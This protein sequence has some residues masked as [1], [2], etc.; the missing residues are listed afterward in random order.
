MSQ[1]VAS[2][3]PLARSESSS[4]RVWLWL[5]I[6]ILILM[7]LASGMG[8]FVNETYARLT[9][10]WAVQGRA[11]DFANLVLVVPTLAISG[12]LAARGSKRAALVWLGAIL[13]TIYNF[14]LYS[15]DVIFNSMF[16]AYIW[17]L[18]CS[19]YSLIFA[20][21]LWNQGDALQKQM[22]G[23]AS[24]KAAGIA[25]GIGA[26]LFAF[27]WLSVIVPAM[28]AG[29]IPAEIVEA[30]IPTNPVH[31]LDL[32]LA[33]PAM[34]LTAL[35]LRNG[36]RLSY[37]FAPGLLGFGIFIGLGVLAI[38]AFSALA[39]M[40]W[41]LPGAIMMG[42]ISAAYTIILVWYLRDVTE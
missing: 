41:S 9:E 5:T 34:A 10:S 33:L 30:G 26:L 37:I 23:K 17:V 13:A 15:F 20:R 32:S 12:L 8:L 19:I 2:K 6:P 25:L 28:L 7:V 36:H 11:Q 29:T 39:G 14:V 35:G 16:L 22:Q 4:V 42:V 27:Q 31:V 18:G 1:A 3:T 40:A 21:E 38:F 24:S